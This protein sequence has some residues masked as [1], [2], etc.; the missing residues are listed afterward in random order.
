MLLEGFM[1]AKLEETLDL[2]SLAEALQLAKESRENEEIEK[3]EE[4][5]KEL[6]DLESQ[7]PDTAETFKSA[8]QK[9]QQLE[10][11]LAD[12]SSLDKHDQEMDEIASEA[13]DSYKELKDLGMNVSPAHAG[14]I[15]ENAAQMLKISLE[16]K[17]AKADKKLRMWRLQL[18]QARLLRD[19]EKNQENDDGI[20]TNEEMI[21]IDRN[22]LLRKLKNND[23]DGDSE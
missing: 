21:R 2:P 12:Y 7:S 14:K 6:A 5:E 22:A 18:E 16:S 10:A 19:L 23:I 3:I 15:F 11:Q 13:M 17:N 9:T 8:I 20:I 4:A 1:T